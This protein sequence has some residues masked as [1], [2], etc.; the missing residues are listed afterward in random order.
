[1]EVMSTNETLQIQPTD[2]TLINGKMPFNCSLALPGS[3]CKS[4]AP[5]SKFRVHSGRTYKLR[6]INSGANSLLGFSIDDHVLTIIT[7]DFVAL[8][9]YNT[10]MALLGVSLFG[11]CSL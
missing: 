1:M 9:P 10:T 11:V 6:V 7:N 5:F 3:H 8:E 4:N 2:N